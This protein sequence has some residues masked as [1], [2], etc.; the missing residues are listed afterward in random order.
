M[1]APSKFFDPRSIPL[2]P[3]SGANLWSSL[4][5]LSKWLMILALFGAIFVLFLPDIRRVQSLQK[6]KQ[7]ND[8]KIAAEIALYQHNKSDYDR[9]K[10]DPEYIERVARDTLNLGKPGETIFRFDTYRDPDKTASRK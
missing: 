10:V 7:D 9:L 5:R 3:K 4:M 6:E 2:R 1:G 8:Q